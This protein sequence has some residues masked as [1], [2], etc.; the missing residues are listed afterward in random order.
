MK[1]VDA[2]TVKLRVAITNHYDTSTFMRF[3]WHI[4]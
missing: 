3:I 1:K 4:K 2:M